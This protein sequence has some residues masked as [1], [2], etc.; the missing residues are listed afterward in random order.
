MKKKGFSLIECM[1]VITLVTLIGLLT[2]NFCLKCYTM[3]TELRLQSSLLMM[4]NTS[5]DLLARDIKMAP[6][7]TQWRAKKK[8]DY[9]WQQGTGQLRWRINENK[10]LRNAG[11]R[12]SVVA[13]HAESLAIE[14]NRNGFKLSLKI[15]AN[16]H[17]YQA[18]QLVRVVR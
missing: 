3:I 1:V 13:L 6:A 12:G 18:T 8:N 15:V 10:L 4:F 2:T 17:C 7:M 11:K 5:F 16:K 14:E 9:S